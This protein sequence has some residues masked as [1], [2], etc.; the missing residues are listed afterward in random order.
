MPGDIDLVN[1]RTGGEIGNTPLHFACIAGHVDIAELLIRKMNAKIDSTNAK[2]ETPL[3]LACK[4]GN[5]GVIERLL[6]A[7]ASANIRD[8][9]HGN[10]PLH[11]LAY[12]N[13]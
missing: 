13:H 5:K 4:Q 8:N 7:R 10:T 11:V 9:Y 6:L 12:S 3:H 2:G 1:F